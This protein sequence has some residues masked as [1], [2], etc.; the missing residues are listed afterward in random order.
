MTNKLPEVGKRYRHPDGTII[1]VTKDDKGTFYVINEINK[2]ISCAP[3]I[4]FSHFEELPEE[5]P[6]QEQING[7]QDC[8]KCKKRI[9]ADKCCYEFKDKIYCEDCIGKA[10]EKPIK[11][12]SKL[13][14]AKE[15]LRKV[16]NKAS[17]G[18][19]RS[20]A[21]KTLTEMF[22]AADKLLNALD[23]SNLDKEVNLD[24][25]VNEAK[26]EVNFDNTPEYHHPNFF[27]ETK[28]GAR[29]IFSNEEEKP[30]SIWKPVD[31]ATP[32]DRICTQTLV[33]NDEHISICRTGEEF[34]N[35]AY[36]NAKF[37]TLTDFI[38]NIEK[39][40]QQQEELKERVEKLEKLPYYQSGVRRGGIML[41]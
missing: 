17:F 8:N 29:A 26:V 20:E 9:K 28:N 12:S 41:T 16:K 27:G 25:G 23:E 4:F 18:L 7:I 40:H 13:E 31:A 39:K 11:E 19:S 32:I 14:A 6:A 35:A 21:D 1:K 22:W 15:E 24:E 37:C 36:R 3:A 33:K 2:K 30:E 34:D 10:E 5:K 38:N